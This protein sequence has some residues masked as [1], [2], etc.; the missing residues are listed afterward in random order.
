MKR[1]KEN[2]ILTQ[3]TLS[4]KIIFAIVAVILIVYSISML[5]PFYWLVMSSQRIGHD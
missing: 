1:D 3:R 4:E 2:Y 5:F